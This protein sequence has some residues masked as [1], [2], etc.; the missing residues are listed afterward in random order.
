MKVF[1]VILTLLAATSAFAADDC[2][3]EQAQVIGRVTAIQSTQGDLCVAQISFSYF[4]PSYACPLLR[5]QVGI[6]ELEC[7]HVVGSQ[8]DGILNHPAGSNKVS[9][10]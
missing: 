7:N 3:I 8:V 10:Y 4:E 6:V 2:S 9:L 1:A 5:S